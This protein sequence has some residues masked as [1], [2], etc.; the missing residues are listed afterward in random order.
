[1][2]GRGA[3]PEHD[4]SVQ[5]TRDDGTHQILGIARGGGLNLVGMA[6]TQLATFGMTLLIARQLGDTEMG[7][8]AQAF[9]VLALLSIF[10]RSGFGAGLVRFVAVHRAQADDAAVRAV[11]RLGLALATGGATVLGGVLFVLAPWVARN[12]FDDALLEAP[13]R[14]VAVALPA[15]AF[16]EAA[17]AAT[18]GF[19]TMKASTLIG[20]IFEPSCRFAFTSGLLLLGFPL[21]AAMATLVGTNVAAAA[22][23]AIALRWRLPPGIRTARY[24]PA[25]LVSF[26]LISGMSSLAATGLIWADTLMLG[27]LRDSSEVGIYS[28]ATR[29]VVLAS[30]VMSAINSAFAPRIA[31][32]CER[33]ST[34]ALGRAY[35][36]V[37]G[38][39]LRLSLP[40][41][42]LLVVFPRDLLAMFG[43]AFQVGATV[44]VVLALGKLVDA[45]TGPCGLMLNMSGRPG[46][47]MVDNIAVLGANVG[48][49]LLLIPRYGMLGAAVAWAV[50]LV[51][52][53]IARVVQVW[54]LLRMWPFGY[55]WV[56][57]LL[58]GAGS[59]VIGAVVARTF[60][61]PLRLVVGASALGVTYLVLVVLLRLTADDRLLLLHLRRVLAR[62]HRRT[63]PD[64]QRS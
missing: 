27:V 21:D 34:D 15:L 56:K 49:N 36:A 7:R 28:V 48:L 39:I 62:S 32:L 61:A 18:Q 14:Y 8:Y 44:T 10:A 52:V 45:A 1:M 23:A 22:L 47:S 12:A 60:Q 26:S 38:W 4:R 58:A 59:L 20:L 55:G 31:D 40:A 50:S 17:L 63:V 3:A 25:G 6:V 5:S 51:L 57:A 13:L 64:P 9:A 11:V 41:F 42:V 19:R 54:L 2:D 33:G 35:V 37:A 46:W 24:R 43:P 16:T 30:F 53:N 29:L